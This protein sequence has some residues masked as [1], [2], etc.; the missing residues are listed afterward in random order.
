VKKIIFF[1]F[2]IVVLTSFAQNTATTTVNSTAVV[3]APIEISKNIDLHFGNVIS[4]Y[5]PGRLILSPDGNRT[6]YGIQI[7]PGS[8]GQVSP[9]E[10]T[11]RHG[12][13]SYSVTLPENFKLFNENNQNHF[14]YINDFT[15]SPQLS[16]DF[17][18]ILKIGA[19][20]NL[21]ANQAAGL[22]SNPTGFS[23]TVSYN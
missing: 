16:G 14:L 21:Q 3:V 8:P 1:L 19:T 15:V 7:A 11:V 6:S 13:F 23:V 17:I 9:A 10:A 5:N 20:L 4:N 22:Y 12:S 2:S 18:D